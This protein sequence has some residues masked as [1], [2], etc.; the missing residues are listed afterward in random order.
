[1]SKTAVVFRSKYGA[2]KAYSLILGKRIPA[3]VIEN[4]GLTPHL[5]EEFDTIILVGGVYAGKITGIDFLK[6][7]A[8]DFSSKR[9]A[10]F[11]VGASPVSDDTIDSIKKRNLKGKLETVPLFYGRGALDE[12]QL[13]F[14]DKNLLSVVRR[15]AEKTK[16]EKRS[17]LEKIILETAGSADWMDESY[18][19]PLIEFIS[20]A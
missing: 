9:I 20:Q 6:K 13:S 10:V 14:M 2:S 17:D 7:Y 19:E 15:S 12:E 8:D 1:M 16:P 11:A 4:E 5:V 3:V 18:L